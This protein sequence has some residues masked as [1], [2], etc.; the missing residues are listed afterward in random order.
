MNMMKMAMM[1]IN[2]MK[3]DMIKIAAAVIVFS[4]GVL[5]SCSVPQ[6][7]SLLSTQPSSGDSVKKVLA[8]VPFAYDVAID[9]ISYNSCVG[10]DLNTSNK[11]H[12]I[13]LGANEGFVDLTGNG[14]VKGGLKLKSDFLLYL[15]KNVDPTFPNTVIMP[16][17]IQYILENSE[18]NQNLKIQ[19]AV[20][21]SA[22]LQVVLDVINPTRAEQIIPGRDGVYEGGVLSDEPVVSSIT[23]NIQFGPD[24]IV[25]AE[26]PRI[27]NIGSK[28]SPDPLEGALGYSKSF[29]AS[30]PV[31][32][33]ANDGTGVG[34][35]QSD[36][37]RGQFNSFKYILA[38][39]FGN[40]TM[41]SP[42][43]LTPS[44][45]L[46][47]LKR[48][49]ETDLKR[50]YG[51]GY[52]LTFSSKNSSL[53]SWRK[54]LLSK[55]NEKNLEDGRLVSGASW[56]CENIV[57]MKANQ[58]NNKK[59]KEPACAELIAGDLTNSFIAA[60]VKNI[61]RHYSEDLWGVGLFYAADTFYNPA[62]RTS[63]PTLC[64]VNKQTNCY[65][66]TNIIPDN[67]IEDIGVQYDSSRECYL[68][69]FLEMGVTYV[70][71]LSGDAA[72]RLGRCAQYAS[73]C[74]RTST[75]Y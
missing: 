63:N 73:I 7:Q 30:A 18:A 15:A 1:K 22:N 55:V 14:A 10:G 33:N 58:F 26:G 3:L 66:P 12:G 34:E 62:T 45:G 59:I 11:L 47:S 75:S 13:K 8:S 9:T 4:S 70:G 52:E 32:A 56:A 67:P 53:P 31:V 68:S 41:V 46:N 61:R 27:Y 36:I 40:E 25:L 39:T 72:R 16:A 35:Q 42:S 71:N 49:S 43:D 50:A 17:Q 19:Y 54:N 5:S 48:K 44:F 57:I 51:R 29:D 2:V 65:L 28:S 23:K 21:N 20:R 38:V 24:K 74:L 6:G 64:L 37:V 60:K 69:R